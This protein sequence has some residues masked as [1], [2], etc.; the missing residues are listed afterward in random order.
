MSNSIGIIKL[1]CGPDSS[2]SESKSY[3]NDLGTMKT[4]RHKQ[5]RIMSHIG[6]EATREF[7]PSM[8]YRH[9]LSPET[10]AA[11]LDHEAKMDAKAERDAEIRKYTANGAMST[12]CRD[13]GRSLPR[14][15]DLPGYPLSED[16][17]RGNGARKS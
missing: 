2:I 5:P 10:L 13:K 7:T 15:D 11:L 9:L 1:N 12:Q 16:P 4:G 17:E 14:T 3:Q 6:Q 8:D